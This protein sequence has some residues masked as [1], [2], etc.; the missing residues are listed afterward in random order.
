MAKQIGRTQ[1]KIKTTISVAFA[2]CFGLLATV[3]TV[4]FFLE[5]RGEKG[6]LGTNCAWLAT[7][8]GVLLGALTVVAILFL[9]LKKPLILSWRFIKAKPKNK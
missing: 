1:D 3:F 2:L 4:L 5:Y 7:V 8:C 6:F 9:F